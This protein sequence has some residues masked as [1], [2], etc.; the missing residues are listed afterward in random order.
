MENQILTELAEKTQGLF[1]FSES[2]A[3]LTIENF[4]QV[5]K[6]QL[7]E[8]LVQL[9]SENPGTLTRID[10]EAFFEKIVNTA[11]PGDQVMVGNAQ[12]FTELHTYL[13]DNFSDILI[14]R[15]EGGVNVPIII[16]AYLSDGTCITIATYAI[17]T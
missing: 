15:I 1:Y 13:K 17:E 10:P 11:D 12:K 3:P 6:D 8:K 2:E 4:G 14:T 9:N 7:N 16:T 5:P